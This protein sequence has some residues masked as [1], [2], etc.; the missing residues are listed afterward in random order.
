MYIKTLM[1]AAVLAAAPTAYAQTQAPASTPGVDKRQEVQQKRID[2]GVESG[3][4]N[5]K[6]AGRLE[7]HQTHIANMESKAKADG[8]VTKN[9]RARLHHAQDQESRRIHH[10]KH[11]RQKAN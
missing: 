3:Q 9:E 5:I 2:K 8:T 7:R 10:Q 4:L 1:I 11:D 6:E